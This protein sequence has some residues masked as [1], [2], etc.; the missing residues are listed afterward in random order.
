M[1]FAPPLLP[2]QLCFSFVEA[3]EPEGTPW[4]RQGVSRST[5]YAR[6]K[7]QRAVSL[8]FELLRAPQ[9]CGVSSTST[10]QDSAAVLS[11]RR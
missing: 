5:F 9:A 11:K 6:R 10:H 7:L 8:A 4:Q 2:R 3:P 1:N